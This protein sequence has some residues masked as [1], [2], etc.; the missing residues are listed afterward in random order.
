MKMRKAWAGVAAV[1][2]AALVGAL[3]AAPSPAF[4]AT[5]AATLQNEIAS[6][7]V[8]LEANITASVEIPEGAD[9]SA[10]GTKI[11]ENYVPTGDTTVTATWTENPVTPSTPAAD[12][13]PA[14]EAPKKVLPQTGDDTDVVL[15]AVIAGV[16]IVLIAA[17]LIVRRHHN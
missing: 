12:T 3:D 4:A 5:D 1:A 11:N 17:A 2:A 16:G 10:T 13:K 9:G 6:G 14:A 7:T 15:P 8:K